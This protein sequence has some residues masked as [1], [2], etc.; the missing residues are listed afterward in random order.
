[1]IAIKDNI[2]PW[3]TSHRVKQW[4]ISRKLQGLP[5]SW[6]KT[7]RYALQSSS[8]WRIAML[9]AP[10]QQ[11]S[12]VL[13]IDQGEEASASMDALVFLVLV[14]CAYSWGWVM[15]CW[16]WLS[17]S[18]FR[19]V[20]YKMSELKV[21]LSFATV[22]RSVMLMFV[23]LLRLSEF[24]AA[25]V[26]HFFRRDHMRLLLLGVLVDVVGWC[27]DGCVVGRRK[28]AAMSRLKMYQSLRRYFISTHTSA[29]KCEI[30]WDYA[31]E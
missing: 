26:F 24:E 5:W 14:A 19:F 2:V 3:K 13:S 12:Q 16:C 9:G 28:I 17:C 11:Q 27:N 29:I 1:M 25:V 20:C 18:I 8:P 23:G 21:N 30:L 6:E 7:N 4:S 15:R 22:F 10:H 31:C